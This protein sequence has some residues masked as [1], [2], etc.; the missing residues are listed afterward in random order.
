MTKN[1][2]SIERRVMTK[3][4]IETLLKQEG[5]KMIDKDSEDFIKGLG[6]ALVISGL[7]WVT[8]ALLIIKYIGE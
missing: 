7:F 3:D 5:D 4:H 2:W 1:H 6:W 8:L